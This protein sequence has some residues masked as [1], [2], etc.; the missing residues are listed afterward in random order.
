MDTHQAAASAQ[1]MARLA[2]VPEHLANLLVIIH[3]W[4]LWAFYS[5][6]NLHLRTAR[7]NLMRRVV[8]S[9]VGSSCWVVEAIVVGEFDMMMFSIGN[10]ALRRNACAANTT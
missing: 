5:D 10:G 3:T 6:M 1:S 7:C 4:L 8:G 2:L 9:C